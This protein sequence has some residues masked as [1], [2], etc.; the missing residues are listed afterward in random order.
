MLRSEKREE[1]RMYSF[2]FRLA[3]NKGDDIKPAIF[4][5]VQALNR[6]DAKN[7]IE[8]DFKPYIC[9]SLVTAQEVKELDEE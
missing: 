8:T 7:K 2:T 6:L 9:G 1:K 5:Q 4:V 3:D